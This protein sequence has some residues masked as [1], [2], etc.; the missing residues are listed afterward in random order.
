MGCLQQRY[1]RLLI[2]S[3]DFGKEYFR[4][5]FDY[6]RKRGFNKKEWSAIPFKHKLLYI[7]CLMPKTLAYIYTACFVWLYRTFIWKDKS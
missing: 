5:T 3:V 1:L 2:I 6:I 7:Q 4:K